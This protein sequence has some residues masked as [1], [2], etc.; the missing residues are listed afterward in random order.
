MLVMFFQMPHMTPY[1]RFCS[2][3]LNAAALI[4]RKTENDAQ[5]KEVVKV[6][7]LLKV[8]L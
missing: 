3:Q 4:Q 6:R 8:I 2:V 7:L 5:F 1:I